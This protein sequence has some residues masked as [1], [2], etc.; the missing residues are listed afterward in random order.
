MHHISVSKMLFNLQ[1]VVKATPSADEKGRLAER[2]FLEGGGASP[3]Q[4]CLSLE[5]CVYREWKESM[6]QQEMC[7]DGKLSASTMTTSI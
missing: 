1:N 3:P 2:L 7:A 6:R 5:N 4:G